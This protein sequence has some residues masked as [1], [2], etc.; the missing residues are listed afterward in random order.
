VGVAA[1]EGRGRRRAEVRGRVGGRV[2]HDGVRR[3]A[4][5]GPAAA[6]EGGEDAMGSGEKKRNRRA[7]GGTT[8]RERSG[9][10]GRRADGRGGRAP[11]GERLT[12][13]LSQFHSF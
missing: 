6:R 10:V 5:W 13:F 1:S 3:R 9:V 4:R 8:G 7:C 11:G 2:V 12:I